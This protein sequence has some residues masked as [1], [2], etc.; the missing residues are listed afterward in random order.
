ME[1]EDVRARLETIRRIAELDDAAHIEQDA[2]WV[3]V[4]RAI[5]AGAARPAELAAAAVEARDIEFSRWY[6]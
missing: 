2:L 3:D 1:I 4:L 5:A 6:A